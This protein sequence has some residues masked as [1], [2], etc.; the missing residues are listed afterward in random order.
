MK[1]VGFAAGI[2]LEA[3]LLCDTVQLELI[4]LMASTREPLSKSADEASVS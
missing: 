3:E 2:V 4:N 1:T